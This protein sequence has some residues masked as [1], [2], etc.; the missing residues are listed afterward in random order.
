VFSLVSSSKHVAHGVIVWSGKPWIVPA[1]VLRTVTVI[2]FAII[3]L[4][5]EMF[6]GVAF[7]SIL[8]GHYFYGLCW[9]LL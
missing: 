2:V 5:L 6:A 3:F 8:V 1:A 4:F 9:R 7:V